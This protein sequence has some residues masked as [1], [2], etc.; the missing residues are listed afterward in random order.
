MSKKLIE[1]IEDLKLN[2]TK[3]T[4]K[5]V[6]DIYRQEKIM[7]QSDKR[8]QKEYDALQDKLKEVQELHEEIE[9]TQKEVI[10]TMGSICENKSKETGEHVKRVAQYSY[11]LAKHYGL[12]E[13]ECKILRD[14]S[15]MHDIGKIAIPD[16][17]LNKSGA[18]DPDERCTMETH[19][20]IGYDILKYSK[21]ELLKTAAI[22]AY[23]HHEKWDGTGYPRG[24][25]GK[26][27]H[28]YGR[29]T[30]L[31][32]VFDALGHDRVYKKAWELD[33][34]LDFLKKKKGKDFDPDLIDIF[35]NNLDELLSISVQSSMSAQGNS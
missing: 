27:I 6:K 3:T 1:E 26:D 24:L 23:E 32:D 35:F 8:Q 4:D 13:K 10:F 11:M 17:I 14:A 21:R 31:A 5:L 25:K 29:I 22:V 16:A 12:D 33:K 20:Q 18:L 7:L 34:I 28:I 19:A 9:A 15:P 2:F 30:A